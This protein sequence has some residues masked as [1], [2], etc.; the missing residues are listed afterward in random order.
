MR[1]DASF[2][3]S[4]LS[5]AL[6]AGADQAEIF[7]RYSRGLA[8]EVKD[9]TVDSLKSSRSFGYGLR[10]LRGGCPGFSYSN[11][12]DD[13]DLVVRNAVNAAAFAD[14][15]AYLDFPEASD[16][17]EV[18]VL[19]PEVEST[20]EDEAIRMA[21]LMEDAARNAD[22]RIAKVRKASAS[23]GSSELLIMNS[24]S[25]HA[26]YRSTV[27]SA[28]ITVVAEETGDAQVGFDYSGSRFLRDISFEQTGINA[29]L[30]ACSLLGAR[31][32]YARKA[33][34][35]LDRAVAVDFLGILS[36]S[37]SADNV[38]K[39][40]S[41][42]SGRTGDLVISPRIRILDNG[43]LP[44]RPGSSPVD[45]EGVPSM[46]KI[47]FDN[48]ILRGYLHNTY[49]SRKAAA[50][51]TGNAARGG[52]AS[53]PSVGATNLYIEAAS[54]EA[55]VPMRAVFDTIGKGLYVVDA[56]GVH[57]A[58]PVSGDFSVGVTGIWI[59]NGE[60]SYP[61]KEAVLSGNILEL[62]SSIEAVGDDLRFYGGVGSP[63]LLI[64][65][66]DISA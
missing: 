31:K 22:P 61:V 11:L 57:T 52:Y 58:N 53:V 6:H 19:D 16:A 39:G 41:L 4:A 40:K 27:C 26:G 33:A 29:A 28:Q 63:S 5:K 15:D 38:Q 34:V 66:M 12:R 8:V 44:G 45:D 56:M 60:L 7:L 2:A 47:L 50:V 1:I 10:V 13:I 42:L 30:Q 54:E 18:A 64:R 65:D 24:K 23:F 46:R 20:G 55:T 14:R 59:E 51:S 49:T 17:P 43:L 48:G 62:F 37:L 25:L 3:E 32:F 36:G 9:R 21:V 35:L